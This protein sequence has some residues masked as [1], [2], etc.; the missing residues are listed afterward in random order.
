LILCPGEERQ[1]IMQV[2]DPFEATDHI[3][4]KALLAVCAL[5]LCGNANRR[6]H[7]ANGHAG[8]CFMCQRGR[9]LG[10]L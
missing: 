3:A 2:V 7:L 9:D 8:N 6:Q 1:E 5:D 10:R 4:T